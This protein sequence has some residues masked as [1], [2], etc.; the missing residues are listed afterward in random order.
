MIMMPRGV[1]E[2]MI[3]KAVATLM[4]TTGMK[5]KMMVMRW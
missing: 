1:T 5:S 2:K 3:A 4:K